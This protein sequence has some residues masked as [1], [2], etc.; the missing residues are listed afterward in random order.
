MAESGLVSISGTKP[1]LTQQ[2]HHRAVEIL[3]LLIVVEEA[4]NHAVDTGR[5]DLGELGGDLLGRADDRIGAPAGDD[6]LAMLVDAVVER[7]ALDAQHLHQIARRHPVAL[8]DDAAIDPTRL[9]LGLPAY[10][11]GRGTDTD[12]APIVRA[13]LFAHPVGY[14][15]DL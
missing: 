12:I 1:R 6:P 2:R 4:E 8:L 5:R 14:R 3:E 15:L 10:D 13:G 7:L 9:G 11:E